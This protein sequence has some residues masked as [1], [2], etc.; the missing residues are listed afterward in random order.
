MSGPYGAFRTIVVDPPWT[1]PTSL[2]GFGRKQGDEW[3]RPGSKPPYPTMTIAEIA[4]LPIRHIAA[5]DAHLYF[6]TPQAFL[7]EAFRIVKGYGFTYS[8]MLHWIKPKRGRP[9][10]PTWPT[11][12]EYCLFCRRG[13]LRSLRMWDTNVFHFPR[14]PHSRK[15]PEFLAMFEQTSPGPRVELFAREARPGW[16][17]VGNAIDGR[18]IRVVL[19]ELAGLPPGDGM[20]G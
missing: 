4:A 8:T 6:W 16:T 20:E 3:K 1:F 18:D 9:G 13:T 7:P 10:F 19:A 12:V 2:P 14:G 17:P 5:K 15:P 11:W